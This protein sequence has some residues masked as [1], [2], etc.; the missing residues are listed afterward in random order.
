MLR[1]HECKWKKGLVFG[2]SYIHP[3]DK[4]ERGRERGVKGND[5]GFIDDI[6]DIE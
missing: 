4:R 1:M 3:M 5:Q 6:R 2:S